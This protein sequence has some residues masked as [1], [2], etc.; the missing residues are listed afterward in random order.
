MPEN[1]IVARVELDSVKATPWQKTV[2]RVAQDV[3]AQLKRD[4]E[5]VFVA[6]VNTAQPEVSDLLV[7]ETVQLEDDSEDAEDNPGSS[8]E[9]E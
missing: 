7:L 9:Q 8:D 3:R 4:G 2:T 6:K 5:F 1:V